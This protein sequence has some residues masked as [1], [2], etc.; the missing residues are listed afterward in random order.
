MDYMAKFTLETL[1][2]C[3]MLSALNSSVDELH[4]NL[5]HQSLSSYFGSFWKPCQMIGT[6]I[7]GPSE[8]VNIFMSVQTTLFRLPLPQN[9]R[10]TFW[11]SKTRV[12]HRTTYIVQQQKLT[13]LPSLLCDKWYLWIY[14][15][16]YRLQLIF[17]ASQF[18]FKIYFL[19]A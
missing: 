2:Q 15:M 17:Y 1:N 9:C 16:I 8:N 7:N 12:S 11:G 19:C 4:H 13:S 5:K 14:I 3:E 18:N 6:V 10:P